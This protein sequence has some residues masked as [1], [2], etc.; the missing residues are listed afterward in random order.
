M[1]QFNKLYIH[2]TLPILLGLAILFDFF[3]QLAVIYLIV[4]VHELS[5]CF[6]AL[7]FRIKL[8][9]IE[10]LPFGMSLLLDVHYIKNPKHEIIVAAAGP[11]SNII[12]S[13]IC[14]LLVRSSIINHETGWFIITA[15]ILIALLNILPAL[16][17]D[18]GRI[19]KAALTLRWGFVKAFN[20]TMM[21]TKLMIVIL[22][23][24]GCVLLYYVQFNFSIFLIIA[25]LIVNIVA[26]RRS[27]SMI[28]MRDILYSKNK[29]ENGIARA[30]TIA[31]RYDKPARKLLKS[32]GYHHYY[33]V[34][35]VDE[36]M[37]HLGTLTETQ[38]IDGLIHKGTRA[39]LYELM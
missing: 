7:F 28:I 37:R 5:H 9:Q 8:K 30:S 33:L 13:F 23:V 24:A 39:K 3:E 15:S 17:L 2:P 10:I 19:L 31:A 38:I 36:D 14:L 35:I 32:F 12:L 29:L 22:T 6:T 1:K 34:E 25:F 26:E 27:G 18:G 16:P 21:L 4:F 11:L 20:F